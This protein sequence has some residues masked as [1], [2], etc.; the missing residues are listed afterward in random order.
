M[1]TNYYARQPGETGEGLHIGKSSGGWDF[2]WRGHEDLNLVTR[3]L[4][5]SWLK[6]PDITIVAEYGVEYTLTEFLERVVD[7]K[8][9]D[10]V[11]QHAHYWLRH[12]RD[13][14]ENSLNHSCWVDENGYPFC[15]LEFC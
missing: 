7:E 5:E 4:W 10:S 2:L 11:I 15:G 12:S 13:S 3:E 1:G 8:P 9:V 14:L 6:Q